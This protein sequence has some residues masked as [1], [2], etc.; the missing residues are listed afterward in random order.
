MAKTPPAQYHSPESAIS[1]RADQMGTHR[2]DIPANA[3]ALG[4]QLRFI[5]A[6]N[7]VRDAATLLRYGGMD[8]VPVHRPR[9]ERSSVARSG[10]PLSG[11]VIVP[12]TASGVGGQ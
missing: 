2:L 8:L 12:V 6:L 4:R 5:E 11:S 10:I 1:Q 3:Q 9:I 7:E